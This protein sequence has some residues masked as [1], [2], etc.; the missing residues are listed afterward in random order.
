MFEL[1]IS[2]LRI[3]IMDTVEILHDSLKGVYHSIAHVLNG[4]VV[5]EVPGWFMNRH[6]L[7][8]CL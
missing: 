5:Y 2:S 8:Q 3:C 7:C 1:W 4:P 6:F